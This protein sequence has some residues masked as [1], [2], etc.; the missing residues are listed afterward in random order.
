MK[1]GAQVYSVRNSIQTM[2]DYG[3]TMKKL[4]AMGYETIQHAGPEIE[5]PYLLRDLTQEAGLIQVCPNFNADTVLET[6]EKVIECVKVLGCDSIMLPYVGNGPMN[7]LEGFLKGWNPLIAPLRKLQEAG[8]RLCYH[9]HDFDIAPISNWDGSFLDY[10]M[11]YQPDWEFILDVAW[12]Q[13]AGVD[14]IDY[15]EK[16]GKRLNCVH[17]KDYTSTINSQHHPL[18]CACGNGIVKLADYAEKVKALGIADVIVEQDNALLYPDP[19]GQM[20]QS[21]DYLKSIF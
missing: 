8:I 4:K 2:E 6:P 21:A 10:L 14:T 7:T 1:L 11:L 13:Y 9:N 16:L 20:E 3:E 15:L 19:F 5:D 17:F 18:F 12:S